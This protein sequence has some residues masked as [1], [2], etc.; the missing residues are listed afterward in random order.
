MNL[1]I[2]IKK[3]HE[4]A[5]IPLYATPGAACFDIH[6]LHECWVNPGA[7]A[8]VP[9]GLAM[10]I[11]PGWRLDLYSRSGH[12]ARSVSLA[13]SVGKIDSDYRG[14]LM[15]LIA[16]RGDEDFVIRPGDRIAQGEV[17]R[18]TPVYFIEVDELEP[19]DRGQG[20]FGSTG[21]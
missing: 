17:N 6:A 10:E 9:T 4:N 3:L 21:A 16:N 14:E 2:K 8:L 7:V 18:V 20:G 19:S 11:P 12:G 5:R 1:D 15:V 13:N